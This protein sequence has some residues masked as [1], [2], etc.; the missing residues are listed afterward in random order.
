MAVSTCSKCGGFCFEAKL[1]E[2]I[3]HAKYP[4]WMIQCTAC[5]AVVGVQDYLHVSTLI[6][7]QNRALIQIGEKLGL[8]LTLTT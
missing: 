7:E 6:L 5:G 3:E 8:D 2:E 1:A 4:T